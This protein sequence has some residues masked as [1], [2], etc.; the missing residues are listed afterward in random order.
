MVGLTAVF[1][2]LS[3]SN[4]KPFTFKGKVATICNW[5]KRG[6]VLII[7]YEAYEK[8]TRATEGD[9]VQSLKKALVDPGKFL[10]IGI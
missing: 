7:G 6:G 5:H 2:F 9:K 10:F 8:L 4:T 3:S 1:I